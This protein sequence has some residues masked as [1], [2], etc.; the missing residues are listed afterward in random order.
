MPGF[1]LVTRVGACTSSPLVLAHLAR[2][3]LRGVVANNRLCIR[4]RKAHGRPIPPLYRSGV[5]YERE[6]WAGKYEEFADMLTVLRRGWGDCDDLA[7][8]RVAELREQGEN[9]TIRIYWRKRRAPGDRSPLTMHVQVRRGP[10]AVPGGKAV[11][12]AAGDKSI[13]PVEDPSRYLGL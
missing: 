2:G 10:G 6:P 8:W 13:G 7:A 5:V 12:T 3:F 9:A 4:Y 1:V 11:K